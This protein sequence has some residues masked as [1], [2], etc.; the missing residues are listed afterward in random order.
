MHA[1][2][3]SKSSSCSTPG[4]IA[5]RLLLS[6]EADIAVGQATEEWSEDKRPPGREVAS[7]ETEFESSQ[8]FQRM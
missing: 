4:F 3:A 5:P 6:K 1:T 8:L 7:T 2:M